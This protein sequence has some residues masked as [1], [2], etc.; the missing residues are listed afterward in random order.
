[1]NALGHFF[2][3][4]GVATTGISLVRE[5]TVGMQPPRFLWVPFELGRPLG[6]PNVPD[7]QRRVIVAA[8]ELF[9]AERGPILADFPED[10]PRV[11]SSTHG[12]AETGLVCPISLPRE[13]P[14]ATHD[15]EARALQEV[16]EL[17]PWNDLARTTRGRTTVG[18]SGLEPSDMVRFLARFL[19]EMPAG[20]GSESGS[21]SENK[22]YRSDLPLGEAFKLASEDLK[23]YCLE[24]ATAQ[25]SGHSARELATW[26]WQDTATGR[27]FRAIHA[28]CVDHADR[29]VRAIAKGALVP[30]S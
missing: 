23:A 10:V 20:S 26:F 8:L 1:M 30:R 24:A 2:E 22:S 7:F 12:D 3:D 6:A 16:E 19:D 25:P 17:A 14:V 29:S 9:E 27:L 4:E 21:E 28:V 15:L 5:H 13:E 18:L 11:S